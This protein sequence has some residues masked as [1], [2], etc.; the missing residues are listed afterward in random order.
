M[1]TRAV[2]EYNSCALLTFDVISSIPCCRPQNPA[3]VADSV[4]VSIQ[5]SA[6]STVAEPTPEGSQSSAESTSVQPKPEESQNIC[7]P[8]T[9]TTASQQSTNLLD[10][11]DDMPKDMDDQVP[12]GMQR[13]LEK[14]HIEGFIECVKEHVSALA[15]CKIRK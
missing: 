11:G 10:L 7:M 3:P 8:V 5:P 6:E 9:S 12:P 2:S 4:A 1:T 15:N 14:C 13:R